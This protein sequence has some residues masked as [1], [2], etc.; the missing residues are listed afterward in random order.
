MAS[1][2]SDS[3]N[4]N[5]CARYAYNKPLSLSVPSSSSLDA[6]AS[7]TSLL[8]L[9]GSFES[10]AEALSREIALGRLN[11]II[12]VWMREVAVAKGISLE[13]DSN[14]MEGGNAGGGAYSSSSGNSSGGSLAALY[15]FGSFRLGVHGPGADMDTLIVGPRYCDRTEDFFGRLY[16]KLEQLSE[17]PDAIVEEL[18]AVPDANVPVIKLFFMGYDL[19]LLYAQLAVDRVQPETLDLDDIS[20]LRS[21]DEASIKSL[22]GTR[23]TDQ[24]L[25]LAPNPESFRICLR[26]LKL[27]A[28]RRGFYS[29]KTGFLG[30][31][32]WAILAACVCQLY[33][34]ASA[35]T[36][37]V[38]FFRVISKWPWPLPVRLKEIEHDSV[39]NLQVWGTRMGDNKQLMP[40]ITPSYPAM[41]STFNVSE[42]TLWLMKSEFKRA[43]EICEKAQAGELSMT[44]VPTEPA[45][46]ASE[47]T[48]P[49]EPSLWWELIQPHQFFAEHSHFLQVYA[50]AAT[51]E[52]W[53]IWEGFV[54]SRLRH[55]G[56]NIERYSYSCGGM[57][58]IPWH[59]K[60]TPP[61]GIA[62]DGTAPDDP[63]T[64]PHGRA[65]FFVA[66]MRKPVDEK[67][68]AHKQQIAKLK[69][70]HGGKLPTP[71][72]KGAV[73]EFKN[74]LLMTCPFQRGP[75]M[76]IEVTHI[77]RA[78]LPDF[79]FTATKQTRPAP[80]QREP[81]AKVET[82]AKAKAEAG[83]PAD[84]ATTDA[85]APEE[86]KEEEAP[87]AAVAA[88]G[89]KR[90]RETDENGGEGNGE[91]LTLEAPEVGSP[92]KKTATTRKAFNLNLS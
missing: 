88:A 24:I 62:I 66:L 10:S 76:H 15:A 64:L 57:L 13:G 80:P 45:E 49:T 75:S 78:K 77:S 21:I 37:I 28:A 42:S 50:H 52:E 83:A 8:S 32:N 5:Y 59:K 51:A 39:L 72:L 87:A 54:E 92:Q 70:Q 34:K 25:K 4:S 43:Q 3:S 20:L 48:P 47:P 35:S 81:K 7:V 67:N 86:V 91:G 27:Y 63:T 84:A 71:D 69:Q 9:F 16:A 89:V 90:K 22:G 41:N 60:I 11:E 26:F 17:G 31:V 44:A 6:T 55:L 33:P 18:H 30:G 29:N 79:V 56:V 85:P 1:V 82:E 65:L 12:Q 19:D 2:P 36:L 23:T 68:V 73:Q 53:R 61:D 74:K 46:G 40:I 58:A 38:K 14:T